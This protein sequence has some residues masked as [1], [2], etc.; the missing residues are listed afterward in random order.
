MLL[1]RDRTIGGLALLRVP[2]GKD[3]QVLDIL[4]SAIEYLKQGA[5]VEPEEFNIVDEETGRLVSVVRYCGK[6]TRKL[7]DK[8]DFCPHCGT[9]IKGGQ[10]SGMRGND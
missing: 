3:W 5:P 8:K 1:D 10:P 4:D 2:H 9:R 6:C 7:D